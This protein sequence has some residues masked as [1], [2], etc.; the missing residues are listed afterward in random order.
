MN[1]KVSLMCETWRWESLYWVWLSSILR[2][3]KKVKRKGSAGGEKATG[4]GRKGQQP[5]RQRVY[6]HEQ[7]QG[8]Q[9]DGFTK[10]YHNNNDFNLIWAKDIQ[11]T[12]S[13]SK[14]DQVC[15]SCKNGF[16]LRLPVAPYDI[17]LSH[18]ER[19]MYRNPT[20]PT[21]FVD[22]GNRETT[23]YYH[24][25][26]EC[27]FPRFP[28]FSAAFFKIG[29]VQLGPSHK[30][31]LKRELNIDVWVFVNLI[32]LCSTLDDKSTGFWKK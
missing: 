29:D 2:E 31:E 20:K 22:S 25:R 27:V 7:G 16:N 6:G 23:K 11:G 14:S 24:I 3:S 15:V 10:V 18:K 9:I 5:R 32:D 30:A 13:V 17:V 4:E 19:W 8:Q 26:R 12:S 21:E 28:Y 1:P